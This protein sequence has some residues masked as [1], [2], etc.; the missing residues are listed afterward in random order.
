MSKVV[1]FENILEE[2]ILAHPTISSNIF[3]CK[4]LLSFY[5]NNYFGQ[6][7]INSDEQFNKLDDALKWICVTL[8][9][10]FS[11]LNIDFPQDYDD[12]Q[13]LWF[14]SQYFKGD[15]FTYFLHNGNKFIEPWDKQD[16]YEIVL[17][18]MQKVDEENY[19]SEDELNSEINEEAVLEKKDEEPIEQD[20]E[21]E[22][23][24]NIIK[25]IISKS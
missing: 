25:D 13:V 11:K 18:F 4:L 21:V 2:K 19:E 3:S 23:L 5:T 14:K 15:V 12:F 7:I 17:D 10:H 16:I 24:E 6:D 9:K 20:E 8:A 22:K 1:R